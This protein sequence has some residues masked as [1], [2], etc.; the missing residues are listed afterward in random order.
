MRFHPPNLAD[1]ELPLIGFD[2]SPKNSEKPGNCGPKQL[3][4]FFV[5]LSN[6]GRA[7]ERL[8]KFASVAILRHQ[9]G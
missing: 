9:S 8:T 7:A 4:G 2:C 3:P 1:F 6:R 5:D